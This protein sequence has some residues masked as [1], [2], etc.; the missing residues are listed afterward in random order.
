MRSEEDL[1]KIFEENKKQNTVNENHAGVDKAIDTLLKEVASFQES[2]HIQRGR[3]LKVSW[4]LVGG[5]GVATVALA[6]ALAVLMPLKQIQPMMVRTFENGY[7]E[8]IRDFS[9]GINFET[10]VD[11]YFL[12]EYVSTRETYDWNKMQYIADYTKAWSAPHVY[13]EFYSFVTSEEGALNTLKDR[14]RIDTR[15]TSINLN[16]NAGV[17]TVRFVKNPQTADGRSLRNI[18][19]TH[20]IAELQYKMLGK[21]KHKDREYNPFGYNIVSYKLLQD[22]TK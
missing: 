7:A 10:E 12:K 8:I 5:L 18:E 19:P 3:L 21:Q 9:E 15:I 11:E 22:K 1:E 20:W 16:Q 14:G 17:A 6:V 13:D 2:K 4:F